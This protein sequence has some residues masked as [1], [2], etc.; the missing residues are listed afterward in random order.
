MHVYMLAHVHGYKISTCYECIIFIK[1]GM[2]KG[3]ETVILIVPE[4]PVVLRVL[5]SSNENSWPCALLK[6]LYL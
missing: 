3:A 5:F 1:Q 4:K 2:Q 6:Q